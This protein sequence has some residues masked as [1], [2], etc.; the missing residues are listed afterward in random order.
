MK[1]ILIF[2]CIISSFFFFI[3]SL[4]LEQKY[5]INV[6]WKFVDEEARF[7]KILYALLIFGI[8]YIGIYITKK[9]CNKTNIRFIAY[10][11]TWTI[12]A[13]FNL[14]NFLYHIIKLKFR[15]G[16]LPEWYVYIDNYYG[17]FSLTMIFNVI[18]SI[19]FIPLFCVCIYAI[20]FEIKKSQ[21]SFN[22]VLRNIV[23][24]IA[25]AFIYLLYWVIYIKFVLKI[26]A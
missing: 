4:Y 23:I 26:F 22:D 24:D 16:D 19:F 17:L 6:S 20:I 3:Y 10:F 13:Y 11:F 15:Y 12:M 8:V 21:K 9:G 2:F 1:K 7:F 18:C 5:T 14:L 25:G